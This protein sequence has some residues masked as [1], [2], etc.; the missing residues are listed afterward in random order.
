M[1]LLWMRIVKSQWLMALLD[2]IHCDITM[3]NDVAVCTY[4]DI[5]MHNDVC[6]EPFLLYI[7]CSMPNYD[8]IMGSM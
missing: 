8:F 3:S 7:F 5:T 1:T 4:H 6:Y 2:N